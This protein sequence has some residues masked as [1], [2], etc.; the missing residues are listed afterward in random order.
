MRTEEIKLLRDKYYSL[1]KE[2]QE[3]LAIKKRISDKG[4]LK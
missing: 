4:N 3:L 1:V 2:N